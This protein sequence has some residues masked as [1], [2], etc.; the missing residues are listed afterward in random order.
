MRSSY[1][2]TLVAVL[3]LTGHVQAQEST[4]K[5]TTLN[6]EL[7]LEKEY[8]PTVRDASKINFLP[9]IKEPEAPK[10]NVEYSGYTIPYKVNPELSV[11]K[12]GDYFT[13][14]KSSNKRGYISAGVSTFVDIDADLGYQIL[15]TEKDQL[16]V[17]GSHRSSNGKVRYLQEDTTQKMKIND[18]WG[19]LSYAHDFNIFKLF[20]DAKYTYSAFNYYGYNLLTPNSTLYQ[21]EDKDRNQVNNIFDINLGVSS[22]KPNE[23]NYMVKV[24]YSYFQ[25]K[26]STLKT[27]DGPKQNKF[28]VDW[29]FSKDFDSDKFIGVAGYFRNTS[30]SLQEDITDYFA[31]YKSYTDVL[32]NPYFKM[33][34]DN[35]DTRLGVDVHI[36]GNQSEDLSIAPN[37]EFNFRPSEK[38]LLYL[39]AKGE[40]TDNNNANMFYENRYVSPEF[41]V[42]DSYTSFDGT[43]G[44][45]SS[46]GYGF[47]FDVFGGYKYTK[48]EHFFVPDWSS[49]K[50][51]MTEGDQLGANFG[52]PRYMDAGVFKLGANLKYQYGNIL[53]VG[54]KGVFNS[55]NVDSNEDSVI[56]PEA[57]NKPTFVTD[58]NVGINMPWV[59]DL[60]LD[61]LYHLETGRKTF[62]AKTID[63]KNINLLNIRGA[64]KLND[65]FSIFAKLDNVMM[66]K[67]DLWYGYPGQ[68]ISFMGGISVKF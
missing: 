11:L 29:D 45:K 5:D 10:A 25:Q 34:G 48:Q 66:Q 24:N 21:Y 63:M 65:T 44:L 36:L 27:L 37:V 61:L 46:I 52:M 59:P 40:V 54:L 12:P 53:E 14:I 19:G 43:V 22:Q 57:W 50:Y 23:L 47:W 51:S 28:Q 55:W 38:F 32:L 41:R 67:Y 60:R 20:T 17:W 18:T 42:R 2:L 35:W 30:Y 62:Y 49:F 33:E 1:I 8:V 26:Y 9:Q 58:F 15:N 39:T 4:K 16:S 64:Y 7:T 31:D 13:E 68:K 56:E 3:C 6:R